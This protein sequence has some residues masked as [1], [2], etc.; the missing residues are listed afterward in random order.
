MTRCTSGKVK[1]DQG[2]PQQ[3]A[4][5]R[6]DRPRVSFLVLELPEGLGEAMRSSM[7]P[8]PSRVLRM[9]RSAFLFGAFCEP[10]ALQA[11]HADVSP[12]SDTCLGALPE[13]PHEQ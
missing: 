3:A 8:Q 2:L 11:G 13:G 12:G 1:P 10:S 5:D 6:M 9:A 4:Q 7:S